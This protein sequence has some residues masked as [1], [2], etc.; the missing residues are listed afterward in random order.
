MRA[1]LV[2]IGLMF[3]VWWS[4]P[5]AAG[6][7]TPADAPLAYVTVAGAPGDGEMALATALSRQ[8]AARGLKPA[9]AFQANVYEVQGTVRLAPGS[10]GK[11][12]VTIIWVVLGPDGTQLGVTRQNKEVRKGSLNKSWGSAANAA[13]QKRQRKA[14]KD[15]AGSAHVGLLY[16]I[17]GFLEVPAIRELEKFLGAGGALDP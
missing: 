5:V 17:F 2:V 16:A 8:L 15:N 11:E 4:S 3:A 10:K 12:N 1:I 7:K 9:T 14:G 6:T 13:A